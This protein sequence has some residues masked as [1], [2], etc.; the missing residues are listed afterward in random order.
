MQFH[1]TP[2]SEPA[3]IGLGVLTGLVA[4][5]C[6]AGVTAD[7]EV[8]LWAGY[9]AAALVNL[10]VGAKINIVMFDIL[11]L[12]VV[13]PLSALVAAKVLGALVAAVGG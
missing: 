3:A 4:Y 13:R 11:A 5:A 6:A 10:V 12:I 1:S 2:I 7:H 8:R 9:V